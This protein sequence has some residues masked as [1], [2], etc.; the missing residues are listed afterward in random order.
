MHIHVRADG[1]I[2]LTTDVR[3]RIENQLRI[4]LTRYADRIARIL[5]WL[6]A[7][8]RDPSV[9]ACRMKI[10]L[11]PRSVTVL[12][13]DADLDQLVRRTVQQAERMLQRD[14]ARELVGVR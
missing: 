13:S 2:E 3:G 6:R 1:E 10:I 11:N 8:P 7:D 5:V 4:G 14:L 9:C 12:D